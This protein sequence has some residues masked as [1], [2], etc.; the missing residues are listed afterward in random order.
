MDKLTILKADLQMLT[1]ANDEYLKTLLELAEKEI[2][3]EGITIIK[4]DVECDMA[5]VQYA[6]YL[7]RKR[8]APDTSMPRYLRYMLNNML[9]SQKGRTDD[10]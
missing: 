2:K 1:N 7:F 6:A 5:A 4:D 9:I 3:R 8:A 10:I